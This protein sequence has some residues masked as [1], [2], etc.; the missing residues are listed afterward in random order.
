MRLPFTAQRG[1]LL[2]LLLAGLQACTHRAE[3]L[4]L[5]ALSQPALL[6]SDAQTWYQST[7]AP[8]GTGSR[9]AT[10]AS[11]QASI[12]S[13]KPAPALLRWGRTVSVGPG[14]D[15]LLLVPLANDAALFAHST[16]VGTRYLVVTRTAAG[17][18]EGS[19]LELLLRRAAAPVDTASVVAAFYRHHR[20]GQWAAPASGEGLV[21]FYSAGYEYRTGRRFRDGHL[22]AGT[23]RLAFQERAGG[24]PGG[25]AARRG[26]VPPGG[27]ATTNF[28]EMGDATCVDWY[29]GN[30]GAYIT[31]TGDCGPGGGTGGGDGPPYTGPGTAGPG[32]YDPL[33][34]S[35]GGGSSSGTSFPT[36]IANTAASVTQD[37]P[38]L[39]NY[40]ATLFIRPNTYQVINVKVELDTN[41]KDLKKVVV[42]LNGVVW[43]TKFSQVGDGTLTNYD[44]ATDTYFFQVTYQKILGDILSTQTTLFG[45]ISPSRG[46]GTLTIP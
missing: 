12:R 26:A 1:A 23:V 21:L 24:R 36:G 29:D 22:L 9:Q 19:I 6:A 35:G 5:P 44:A 10:V 3:E 34:A 39:G 18:L 37:T 2:G 13:A 41:A 38:T 8:L 4:P 15:Q 32:G 25:T 33:P 17:G 45:T 27:G 46:R 7:I 30:T 14:A 43:L 16:H 40:A 31:S 11:A 28:T 20:S 42:T